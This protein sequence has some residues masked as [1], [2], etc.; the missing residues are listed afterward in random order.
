MPYLTRP[1]QPR[2]HYEIDDYTD[3][4]KKAPA[5][6]LQHGYARSS[7]FWYAWI[8]YLSRFYRVIRLDLR[9]LGLSGSDFDVSAGITFSA[10]LQD[11]NDLLDHLEIESIHYC[12]E[13]SAGTLGMI[14]AAECPRRVRTLSV[15]SAP[16]AMTEVDKQSALAGYASR[17]EML[18][19]LGSRGWLDASNAGR[20]YP[21]DADP[22][23][24]KWTVDE[25]AKSDVEVLISMF[26]LVSSADAA[27][28]LPRINAPVLALYPQGGVITN[29]EHLKLLRREIR[30]VC[31]VRVASQSHSINFTSPATCAREVLHFIA[32]HDGMACHEP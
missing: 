11:F 17:V 12:G 10:Y 29:D 27:P 13:S 25:M 32:Q 1:G 15:I 19:A 20:R 14:F 7:R 31:I 4:W 2:L 9:G 16:V 22:G 26:Q 6:L 28:Y 23:M 5:I 8:P 3:P 24:L 30:D 18:R 21:A